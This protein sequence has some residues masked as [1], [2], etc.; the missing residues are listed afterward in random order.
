MGKPGSV[1]IRKADA[2]DAVQLA[3]LSEQ[4]GYPA[5]PQQVT[6]R[7]EAILQ[8]QTQVVFAAC[9]SDGTVIGWIDVFIALRLESDPF[10]GIGGFVVDKHHRGSG[11]GRALLTAAENWA[12]DHG[13][14]KL[15]IRSRTAR[16]D[17]HAVFE[18]LGFKKAKEQ[19]VF[20]KQLG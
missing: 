5:A 18:H 15:R 3:A 17:S 9:L 14:P 6:T 20:D 2:G 1:M 12:R 16:I 7:L 11:A 8:S 19:F 10:A 13:I 4:L